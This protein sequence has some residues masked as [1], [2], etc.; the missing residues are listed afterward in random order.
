MLFKNKA[1]KD[2]LIKNI[3]SLGAPSSPSHNNKVRMYG[4]GTGNQI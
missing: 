3:S 1:T 2:L 4:R